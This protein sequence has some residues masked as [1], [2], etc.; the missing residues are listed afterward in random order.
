MGL[1][2][3]EMTAIPLEFLVRQVVLKEILWI[4]LRCQLEFYKSIGWKWD[5][6][7]SVQAHKYFF[8]V[9][10]DSWSVEISPKLDSWGEVELCNRMPSCLR[11]SL[12]L[13]GVITRSNM[14]TPVVDQPESH[15]SK[16]RTAHKT[17]CAVM[18][19]CEDN[20]MCKAWPITMQSNGKLWALLMLAKHA[21]AIAIK[22]RL[23]AKKMTITILPCDH[24][25]TKD[26]ICWYSAHKCGK[27][28]TVQ[29]KILMSQW[30]CAIHTI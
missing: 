22:Q 1:S 25:L 28:S 2:H 12:F 14:T 13:C 3:T 30:C 20:H 21:T 17:N 9:P 8:P 19:P 6:S 7:R 27:A 11:N 15:G 5:S 24:K 23:L 29:Y 16:C 10:S 4:L 26:M 18:R